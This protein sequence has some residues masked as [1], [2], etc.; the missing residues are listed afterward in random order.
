MQQASAPKSTDNH[1]SNTSWFE[2]N[3]SG[4]FYVGGPSLGT[5]F[6]DLVNQSPSL[7]ESENVAGFNC[8]DANLPPFSTSPLNS[9]T[10][11]SVPD[12]TFIP[13]AP[14]T[15]DGHDDSDENDADPTDTLSSQ[16]AS[17]SQRATQTT[18]RLVRPNREP[19]TVSSSEV[20][21]ALEIV[22]NLIHIVN[23]ITAPDRDN[24]TLDATTTDY[25]LALSALACHQH[26]IALFGAICDAIHQ[27]VQY[28][29]EQM[30]QQQQKQ[31]RS[32]QNSNVGPSVVAQ[33]VMVLQLMMHLINRM[34]RSLF[35]NSSSASQYPGLF[36]DGHTTP[37]TPDSV[38]QHTIDPKQIEEAANGSSARGGLVFLVHDL[39]ETLPKEHEKLRQ[40]IQRLQ[41]DIDH[42]SFH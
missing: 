1:L 13:T 37:I 28:K 42:S 27:C 16:L 34:D 12:A 14:S 38:N 40:S 41:I 35:Q 24:I 17:L 2:Q 20:N 31:H 10:A 21:E 11:L 36:T 5:D 22:N 15:T 8:W 25:G 32:R 18:R 7:D 29:Q 30:Q 26:L 19:L 39:V 6:S 23:N 9:L 33:F 3:L 4:A